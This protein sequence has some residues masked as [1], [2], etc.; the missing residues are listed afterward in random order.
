MIH[1]C[2]KEHEIEQINSKLDKLGKVVL[3]NGSQGLVTI[4]SNLAE[5]IEAVIENVDTIKADVKVL[6]QFQVQTETKEQERI[7]H[8]EQV[9]QW[10]EERNTNYRWR[11]GLTITSIIAILG[12][13][14]T[15]ITLI[16]K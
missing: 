13:I 10:K 15:L 6:L 7:K 14:I 9:Q 3:G 4:T 8:Q 12:L 2:N 11:V 16:Y 5:R 1:H